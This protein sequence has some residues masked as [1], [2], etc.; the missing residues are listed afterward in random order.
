MEE[1]ANFEQH[2][3][4][5]ALFVNLFFRHARALGFLPERLLRHIC[6]LV[7]QRC[8]GLNAC[9]NRA[10]YGSDNLPVVTMTAAEGVG[11]RREIRLITVLG[12]TRSRSSGLCGLGDEMTRRAKDHLDYCHEK[13]ADERDGAGHGWIVASPKATKTRIPEV[14]ESGRQE[15][16]KGCSQQNAGAEMSDGK[17]ERLRDANEGESFGNHGDGAC[18]ARHGK[19]DEQ[20]TYMKRD[21]VPMFGHHTV[22]TSILAFAEALKSRFC[23]D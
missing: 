6:R 10:S 20:P 13:D 5:N 8:R 4:Q 7:W 9:A 16:H 23:C 21:I 12:A 15:V 1:N 18:Q 22:G 14:D 19:N 17:E 3:L 11:K 2:A